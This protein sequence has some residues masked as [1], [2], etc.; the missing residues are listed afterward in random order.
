M[1]GLK[2]A[3]SRYPGIRIATDPAVA[4][5]DPEVDALCDLAEQRGLILMVGQVFLFNAA[6][7]RVKEYLAQG[8]L[9]RLFYISMVRTNLGFVDTLHSFRTSIHEGD[10]QI[11]KVAAGEPLKAECDHFLECIASGRPPISGGRS[12]AGA[13]RVLDALTRS[14]RNEGRRESV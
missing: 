7:R 14:L 10:I 1:A 9:G 4:F 6:I 3:E 11:P 2:L 13:V 5:A 8:E 12:G